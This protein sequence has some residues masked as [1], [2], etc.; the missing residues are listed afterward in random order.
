M[1]TF[2]SAGAYLPSSHLPIQWETNL[3]DPP[4]KSCAYMWGSF[5]PLSVFRL[6]IE[7]GGG[8]FHLDFKTAC[9]FGKA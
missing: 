4:S 1:Q 2:I 3:L 5:H 8:E 9:Y 7:K 6:F